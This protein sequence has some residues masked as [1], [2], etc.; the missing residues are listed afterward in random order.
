MEPLGANTVV[1]LKMKDG[2]YKAVASGSFRA[3]V[4][5]KVWVTFAPE[6]IHVFNTASGA[7]I[8]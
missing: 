3:D 4:G 7:A 2:L 8:I 5:S 1:D 6:H